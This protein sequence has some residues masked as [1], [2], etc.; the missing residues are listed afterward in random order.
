HDLHAP[1]VHRRRVRHELR[2][3]SLP[4]EH[5]GTGL[6]V[7]LPAG[8]VPDGGGGARAARLLP[9]QGLAGKAAAKTP[10]PAE[11]RG[12]RG[13]PPSA[14]PACLNASSPAIEPERREDDRRGKEGRSGGMRV[15][16]ADPPEFRAA[17]D[18]ASV[19]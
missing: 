1:V 6:A 17:V 15:R 10:P 5:A 7:R 8:V 19:R 12:A 14:A 11:R 13:T 16:F 3:R 2:P 18:T 4:L 9:R